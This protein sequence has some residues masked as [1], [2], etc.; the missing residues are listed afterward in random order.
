M[1]LFPTSPPL[2]SFPLF[3]SRHLSFPG[4]L[5]LGHSPFYSTFH[6]SL[7]Y[8]VRVPTWHP[9]FQ[10]YFSPPYPVAFVQA[11]P[12]HQPPSSCFES[13]PLF[14]E[15]SVGSCPACQNPSFI[16][17]CHGFPP[18]VR[19]LKPNLPKEVP[20]FQPI[21]ALFHILTPHFCLPLVFCGPL[22]GS[23]P[24]LRFA[25]S[26]QRH[27]LEPPPVLV[28]PPY[29]PSFPPQKV[30]MTP[31]LGIGGR[32]HLPFVKDLP[33]PFPLDFLTGQNLVRP[34]PPC[35]SLV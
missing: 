2:L 24:L 6:S 13:S 35:P 33:V 11:P 10:T 12:M 7:E 31:T 21:S 32:F 30:L 23:A 1:T 8:F 27:Q 28:F 9:F 15:L 19:A 14:L 25:F 20:N 17:F 5:Y 18:P 3:L 16:F 29:F 26:L 22:T 4:F 34:F